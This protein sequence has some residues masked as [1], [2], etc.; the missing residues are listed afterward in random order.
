MALALELDDR[1]IE[2][3]DQVDEELATRAGAAG[4]DEAEVL[5]RDVR[6]QGQLKL[7]EAQS[8]AVWKDFTNSSMM[9]VR[10]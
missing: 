8:A 1:Q 3:L 2:V 5:G 6:V 9:R 4:F 10:S 7:A